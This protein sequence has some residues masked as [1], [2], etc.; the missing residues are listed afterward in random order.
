MLIT[1]EVTVKWNRNNKKRFV[2]LGYIF[3][4]YGNEFMVKVEDLSIH[5]PNSVNVTCDYCQ[6]DGIYTIVPKQWVNYLKER[7]N[8]AKDTCSSCRYKK[9]KDVLKFKQESN[10]LTKEDMGYWTFKEN[11][12]KALDEFI[13]T[14]GTISKMECHLDGSALYSALVN[15]KE[16]PHE[17]AL[18]LGYNL[19]EIMNIK[20]NGYYNDFDVFKKDIEKLI[21]KYGRFPRSTEI[22]QE[23]KIDNRYIQNFGGMYGI[24]RKMNYDG[25][26]DLM[27]NNKFYNNSTYEL[28]SANFLIFNNVPY[29][30]ERK[31][32]KNENY[33]SD[34]MFSIIKENGELQELH[35]EVWG[36]EDHNTTSKFGKVYMEVREIKEKLYKKNNVDYISIE[37]SVF[38]NKKYSQIQE[39]LYDIF[40]PYLNLEFKYIKQEKFLSFNSLSDEEL[41]V[42]VLKYSDNDEYLPYALYLRTENH[43]LYQEILKRFK[44]YSEFAEKFGKLTFV[45]SNGYWDKEKIFNIFKH[46]L[47]KYNKILNRTE[48]N[49]L[50]DTDILID[51]ISHIIS[52]LNRK[53]KY[54][55]V[56]ELKIEFFHKCQ[57][58][59]IVI[60]KSEIKWLINI[61]KNSTRRGN[62]LVSD[63][64]SEL[65][66]L[67]LEKY[68]DNDIKDSIINSETEL[69]NIVFKSF[70]YM[71]DKYGHILSIN[72][73]HEFKKMDS[74][75]NINIYKRITRSS[76]GI[77]TYK[78]M[79]FQHC[80]NND[81]IL[82]NKEI[83]W[84]FEV[85]YGRSRNQFKP[86]PEH[87]LLA[88]KILE[89]Y[90]NSQET[91]TIIINKQNYE[92]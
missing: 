7:R 89:K 28:F 20:P 46:M 80:V 78:L 35:V 63:E 5:A 67:I 19:D 16:T 58:N 8:V 92:Q 3:T 12:L 33:R 2:E 82:P 84:L 48:I 43:S 37:P 34:F 21:S 62:K 38:I 25:S 50:K 47:S 29:L 75:L 9:Y 40:K 86:T 6:D 74:N 83:E 88:K 13:K 23:L 41:M 39:S 65:A 15:F 1:K 85:S 69:E 44:N 81:I 51:D 76:R 30:R 55:G 10:V 57:Q 54:G 59:N 32:F 90:N 17:L 22:M 4:N 45:K 71:I 66:K 11:R 61:S 24:K 79:Y 26:N 36:C 42:E 91:N 87:Q 18:E 70:D 64:Y 31:P 53:D 14:Y 60:P 27:D 72:E 56:F 77:N 73:Y 52:S 49:K 68:N